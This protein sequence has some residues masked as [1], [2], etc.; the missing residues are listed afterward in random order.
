MNLLNESKRMY[1]TCREDE[2]KAIRD[3][4]AEKGY[5]VSMNSSAGKGLEKYTSSGRISPFNLRNWKWVI[6]SSKNGKKLFISLQAFD[7]D[8]NSH[9]HHVLYDRLG[10]YVFDNYDAEDAFKKMLTTNIDLPMD[11]SKFSELDA[12]IDTLI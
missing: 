10:L 3:H 4:L 5:A 8:P 6:A 7:Q 11:A 12:L 9:N 2:R 1:E